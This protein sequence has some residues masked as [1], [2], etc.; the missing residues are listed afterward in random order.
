MKA[1]LPGVPVR[2]RGAW[3]SVLASTM[4]MIVAAGCA[5]PHGGGAVDD[6][7]AVRAVLEQQ[8]REWNAGHLA[9]FME[10]YARSEA[11]RFASG[12]SVTLGWQKVNDRYAAKYGS[13]AAMGRLRFSELEVTMLGPDAAMAF[14]HWHLERGGETPS[15]VFTLILR[16]SN[17]GWRIVHDHT[18]VAE[19]A[20]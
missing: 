10:T 14:G 3:I 19:K 12:G 13:G 15:G 2:G 5:S 1:G 4:L 9:G 17:S 16:K 11:T 6:S 8:V 20:P 18:S 7:A